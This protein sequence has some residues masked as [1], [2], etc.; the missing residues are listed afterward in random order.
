MTNSLENLSKANVDSPAALTRRSQALWPRNRRLAFIVA[1]LLWTVPMLVIAV[2][3]IHNPL[4]HTVTMGSYHLAAENWWSARSLYVGPSGMN[5]LPHFAVLYSPF[6]F[7]PLTVSEI[8]WRFCAAVT[9]AGGLWLLTRELFGMESERPFLWA[10][11]LAMPLCMGALRNGNANAIFGG[12]TLL[13]VVATLQKRWWLAVGWM[14]LATALKPLGFVLLLLASIY[15]APITRR[16]PA[17]LLGLAIFPFFFGSPDYVLAQYRDAWHNLRDCAAVSEHR[18]A[19]LNGI[20]R[21][22]GAPLSAGPSTIVR[23][24]AGGVTAM[25]W[26]WGA[27]RLSPALRCLWLYA[28]ATAYLMLF[29]PMT[30][31]NSYVILAPA[32]GVWGAWFL[33][34]DELGGRRLSWCIAVMALCMGLLPNIMRPLFGNYFALF[35]HPLMTILFVAALIHFIS[36]ADVEKLCLQ[37]A[38]QS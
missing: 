38:N 12:V 17:A 6:H 32:L 28:L 30:E 29:N 25:A 22:F 3:V 19:D 4:R 11:I 33:C 31:A 14:V 34:S 18:F 16:L 21:T 5:Y 20:L 7:L 36:R 10:S 9:L 8:V 24:L 27:Q 23:V 2:L 1:V 13:A 15:Y 26:L 35:W 37:P